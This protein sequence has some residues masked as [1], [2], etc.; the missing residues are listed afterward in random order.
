MLSFFTS[1]LKPLCSICKE[2]SPRFSSACF[3]CE[4]RI[5]NLVQQEPLHLFL[6]NYPL[7]S[8]FL[9][10]DWHQRF[11]YHLKKYQSPALVTLLGE[12]LTLHCKR[13]FPGI[14]I[15]FVPSTA[16][17]GVHILQALETE[18]KK[19]HALVLKTSPLRKRAF[20][21]IHKQKSKTKSLRLK[22]NNFEKN[23]G[24]QKEPSSEILLIDD[25]VTTGGTLLQCASILEEW[26]YNPR[27]LTIGLTP[28]ADFFI[29]L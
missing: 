16:F 28:N 9:Y 27:L 4:E 23:Y 29:P 11:L 25:I 22:Q 24:H 20:S 14:P 8:L 21:L 6:K 19:N 5:T 1:L 18:M 2:E 15:T 13:H 12:S 17:S 10:E 26:G 3:R 7:Q